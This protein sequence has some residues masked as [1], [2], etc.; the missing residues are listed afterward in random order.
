MGDFGSTLG[1]VFVEAAQPAGV[2]GWQGETHL[3]AVIAGVRV[4]ACRGDAVGETV[5][6]AP[7]TVA[8]GL[9]CEACRRLWARVR[10][11]V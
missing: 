4:V 5:R 8:D 7:E 1:H 11:L 3:L 2:E 10:R 9:A 6:L